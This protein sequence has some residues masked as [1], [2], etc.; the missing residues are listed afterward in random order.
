MTLAHTN[1]IRSHVDKF[2]RQE[3]DHKWLMVPLTCKG[4]KDEF[5]KTVVY[6]TFPSDLTRDDF[7]YYIDTTFW[8]LEENVR[9]KMKGLYVTNRHSF[10]EENIEFDYGA[11]DGKISASLLQII[12]Q[13]N[14]SNQL[15]VIVGIISLVRTPEI[16]WQ[17]NNDYWQ[18][19][20]D[21]VKRGLQFIFGIEAQNQLI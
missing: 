2:L 3:L 6:S 14:S 20:K 5:Q 8:N 11:K 18:S 9:K 4:G 13:K 15:D 16:G 10:Q 7:A 12:A 21:R 19:D 1:T 17:F